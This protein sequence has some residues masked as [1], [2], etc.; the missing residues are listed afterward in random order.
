MITHLVF[1]TELSSSLSVYILKQSS[2]SRQNFKIITSQSSVVMGMPIDSASSRNSFLLSQSIRLSV[3]L[4]FV[5]SYPSIKPNSIH[6]LFSII[7]IKN[8][9]SIFI[10]ENFEFV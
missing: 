8:Q 9:T 3:Y 5:S 4:A 1:L 6:A 7:Y 10:P 2:K